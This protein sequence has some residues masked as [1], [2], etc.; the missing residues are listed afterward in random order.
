M[1]DLLLKK[2]LSLDRL[3]I[4]LEIESA[5]GIASAA[6]GDATRQS[7]MSRQVNGLED[8]LSVTLLDR[9]SKP[10]Q[11]TDVAREITRCVRGFAGDLEDCLDNEDQ[12]ITI[13]TGES[14]ILWLLIP[15][16]AKLKGKV[17]FRNMRSR[18][19]SEA[20]RTEQVELA[21]HHAE[22]RSKETQSQSIGEYGLTLVGPEALGRTVKSWEDLPARD[23][24]SLEGDG[25]TRRKVNELAA[26]HPKG[27]QG[28][29]SGNGVHI[30][31]SGSRRVLHWII[32][33]SS[34]DCAEA[35]TQ[36]GLASF[37]SARTQE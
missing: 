10:Y 1:V 15:R 23:L 30:L 27:P 16:L 25:H 24:A 9:T 21:I 29:S 19:A 11:L 20:M 28:T 34:R 12:T 35:S 17:R 8:A 13:A 37:S 22:H 7:Q 26:S 5:G 36:D 4:L 32:R 18:D 33:G 14:V 31:P 2:G 6:V 3:A